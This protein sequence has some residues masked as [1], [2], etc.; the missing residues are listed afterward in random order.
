[1]YMLC[2]GIMWS[3]SGCLEIN[4]AHLNQVSQFPRFYYLALSVISLHIV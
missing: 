4:V 1:M 2:S 3:W